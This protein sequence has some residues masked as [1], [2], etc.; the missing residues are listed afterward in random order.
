MLAVD[1]RNLPVSFFELALAW[2][3]LER[4]QPVA[5]LA[6]RFVLCKARFGQCFT[7]F[8]FANDRTGPAPKAGTAAAA[9]GCCGPVDDERAF[10]G[11]GIAIER[12]E[13]AVSA[14]PRAGTLEQRLPDFLGTE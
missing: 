13:V 7:S 10:A 14:A 5:E 4:L 8:V 11:L 12:D 1:D 3:K 6:E 2:L 9:A